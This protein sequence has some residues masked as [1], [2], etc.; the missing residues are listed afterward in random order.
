MLIEKIGVLWTNMQCETQRFLDSDHEF[1]A[2]A[3]AD[4]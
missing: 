2:K 4:S 1:V 3:Q